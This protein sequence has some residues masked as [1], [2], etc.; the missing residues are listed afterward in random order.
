[1]VE[2]GLGQRLGVEIALVGTPGVST[3]E[4]YIGRDSNG[5]ALSGR[6][7]LFIRLP[8]WLGISGREKAA[9]D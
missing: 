2:V 1:M 3:S 8:Q 6:L 5:A 4:L 9:G 7:H